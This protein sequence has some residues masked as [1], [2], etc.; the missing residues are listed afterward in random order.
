MPKKKPL[1]M[2]KNHNLISM[3]LKQNF[4]T[5]KINRQR[6]IYQTNQVS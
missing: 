1:K 2:K 5:S 4:I 6:V 3:T